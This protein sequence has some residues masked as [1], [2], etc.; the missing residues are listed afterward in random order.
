MA[1]EARLES[2]YTSKAYPEF[3]SRSLRKKNEGVLAARLFYLQRCKS[4]LAACVGKPQDVTSEKG[5]CRSLL[6]D[7]VHDKPQKE[8]EN[9]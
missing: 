6:H 5:I 7:S 2:V 1:E 3:E 9:H 4:V 8:A